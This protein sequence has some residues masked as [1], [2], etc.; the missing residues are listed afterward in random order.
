MRFKNVY[1]FLTVNVRTRTRIITFSPDG[2]ECYFSRTGSNGQYSIFFTKETEPGW[3]KPVEADFAG[4]SFSHE[5][6]ISIYGETLFFGSLRPL[7]GGKNEYSIWTLNRQGQSWS[8]PQPLGFMA[9]Y[10]YS[11][12]PS[13]GI[14]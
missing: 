11:H 1:H 4:G 9:R 8:N 7:P 13:R 12:S 3:T 14:R 10:A 2:K 5:S 6:Y